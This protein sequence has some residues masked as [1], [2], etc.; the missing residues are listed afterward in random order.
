VLGE[1][2][3]EVYEVLEYLLK[4]IK[5]PAAIIWGWELEPPEGLNG[6][7]AVDRSWAVCRKFEQIAKGIQS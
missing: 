2:H 3:A 6:Q 7:E 4:N 5:N 1:G